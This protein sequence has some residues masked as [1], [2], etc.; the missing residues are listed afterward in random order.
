MRLHY[1]LEFSPLDTHVM[2][3]AAYFGLLSRNSSDRKSV[4]VLTAVL[5][6]FCPEDPVRYDFALFGLGV[7][8]FI[9]SANK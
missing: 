2:Q 1:P 6:E 3:V 4:E 7:Q 8:G 9:K 5:R